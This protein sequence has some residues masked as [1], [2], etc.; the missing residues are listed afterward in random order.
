MH[1]TTVG[2]ASN[3]RRGG[4]PQAD[5]AL[6]ERSEPHR[7]RRRLPP[8]CSAG[9]LASLKT[10]YHEAHEGREGEAKGRTPS[11]DRL[12]GRRIAIRPPM[13]AAHVTP[14]LWRGNSRLFPR[15]RRVLNPS[16]FRPCSSSCSLC[17]SWLRFS[18]NLPPATVVDRPRDRRIVPSKLPLANQ[19]RR[20]PLIAR[21]SIFVSELMHNAGRSLVFGRNLKPDR[22]TAS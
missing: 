2:A 18:W 7:S 6:A 16:R 8:P 9:R 19:S 5:A 10:P 1:K 12:G 13:R 14:L 21:V 11:S 17:P 20:R 4:I 3:V 15:H 22:L